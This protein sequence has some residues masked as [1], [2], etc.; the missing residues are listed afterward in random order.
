ML[1]PR[2]MS[3][4]VDDELQSCVEALALVGPASDAGT[5]PGNVGWYRWCDCRPEPF[6]AMLD[7]PMEPGAPGPA[8]PKLHCDSDCAIAG[9]RPSAGGSWSWETFGIPAQ[10][11]SFAWNE[12]RLSL[13]AAEGNCANPWW[14]GSNVPG[15]RNTFV[16]FLRFFHLARRFWNQT[17]DNQ[18]THLIF[19]QSLPASHNYKLYRILRSCT[20]YWVRSSVSNLYFSKPFVS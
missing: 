17:C 16:V 20:V 14:V 8:P 12:H 2:H 4:S 6:D 19:L 13:I 1:V 18:N 3:L 9:W 10:R 5:M 11:V 7:R 15:A